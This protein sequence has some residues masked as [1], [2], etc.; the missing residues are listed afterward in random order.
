M[1]DILL[2]L[3]EELAVVD[4]LAGKISLIVYADPGEPDAYARARERLQE[5]RRK[6]REPVA[7]PFQTADRPSPPE[8]A[9][10]APRATSARCGARR[11]TSPRAT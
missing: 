1:P 2:L 6:L 11:S 8:K 9:S 4:N 5:L 3:T 10:S 7:I